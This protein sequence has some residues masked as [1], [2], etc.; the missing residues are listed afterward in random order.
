MM[1]SAKLETL[2]EIIEMMEGHMASPFKKEP[3]LPEMPAEAELP[4]GGEA[5]IEVKM[6]GDGM[7]EDAKRKLLEMYKT[8]T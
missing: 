7:D 5:E 1:D 4:E 3:K 6:S 8:L 2:D